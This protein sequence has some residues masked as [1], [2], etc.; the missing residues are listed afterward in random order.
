M[1]LAFGLI[2]FYDLQSVGFV[3]KEMWRLFDQ[4][5]SLF[6]RYP[7]F[8]FR[9]LLATSDLVLEFFL[10]YEPGVTWFHI[11]MQR[12]FFF[13][14]GLCYTPNVLRDDFEVINIK[15]SASKVCTRPETSE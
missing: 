12:N 1:F 3:Y 7:N 15:K 11:D 5:L 13:T 14:L 10:S 4:H 9:R 6:K 8:L 2:S